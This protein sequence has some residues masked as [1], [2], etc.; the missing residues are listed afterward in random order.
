MPFAHGRSGP[1]RGCDPAEPDDHQPR[2]VFRARP[3]TPPIGLCPRGG[4]SA[5]MLRQTFLHVPG[6]GYRT[7]ERLWRADLES[8]NDVGTNKTAVLSP[9]LRATLEA[10]LAA[11]EAALR[12]GRYRYF[13]GRLPS[14]EHWRAWPEFRGRVAFLDIET[15]GLDIGRDALTVV[16]VYDGSRRRSFIRGENLEDLPS[17]LEDRALLVTFNG[18]RFDV[19]FLRHAFPRMRLDQLHLDLVGPFHRLGY[20]GGLKRIERRLGIERSD[21]TAGMSGVDAI[22]L[23]AAYRAGDDDALETLVAYN[24]EDAVNLEPLAEF[25]YEAMRSLLLDRGFVTA[26]R[27]VPG[28]AAP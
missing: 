14:R 13:A 6:V 19:P 24:L 2:R 16:G 10:E 26:D 22:R 28:M 3:V 1:E 5:T 23:W 27:Y 9:R 18:A 15:T 12:Q 21:E 4:S 8:W 11:S 17:A 20:W 25:A 7:E